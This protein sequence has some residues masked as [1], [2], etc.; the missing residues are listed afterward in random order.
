MNKS[1]PSINN[2]F[3]RLQFREFSEPLW[4]MSGVGPPDASLYAALETGHVYTYG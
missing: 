4:E 1:L 3:Q 2:T